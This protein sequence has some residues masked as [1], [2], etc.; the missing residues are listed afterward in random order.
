MISVRKGNSNFRFTNDYSKIENYDKAIADT[1][2]TWHC[3]HKLEMFFTKKEL[4][5]M[6]R[7][8][9]V[10]ARELIFLTKKDHSQTWI[11]KGCRNIRPN[12]Q[13]AK[14][15]TFKH[16]E[17]AKAKISAKRKEKPSRGTIGMH[18]Y[19]NGIE[20]VCAFTCPDGYKRGR[21]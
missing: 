15:N 14:G 16:T 9:N 10:P 11:H 4:I 18:W 6:G 1:T 19:N 7:Y 21:K 5:E 2:Q 12:N 20:N 17:E 8:Y 13:Y 3:H